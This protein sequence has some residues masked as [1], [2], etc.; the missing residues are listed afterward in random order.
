[1]PVVLAG[2]LARRGISRAMITDWLNPTLRGLLPDPSLLTDMDKAVNRLA[3]AVER[4]EAVGIFGDY[5]VD[6]ASSAALVHDVLTSL[7]MQVSIHIPDRFNEGYG[8]N[9]PAL[10]ALR[11]AGCQL[12]LTVDCGITAHDPLAAAS[13]AGVE[14][15]VIDHHVAGPQLPQAT[16]VVNPN[17]LEDGGEHG[18]LAAAGVCFLVMVGLLRCLRQRGFFADRT[19]PS[20]MQ[21]LDLVAL[22]TIADVVPLV[23]LNR[24]FVRRG[25]EVMARRGR[26]GLAALADQAQVDRP[27][28]AHMLGF[29]LGPRINA[30]GRIGQSSLGV[31]T[32]INTDQAEALQ[33]ASQLEMLNTQRRDHEQAV[34][35]AAIAELEKAPLAPI[36]MAIGE[37]WHQ[38]VIGIA[39]SR[40][41]DRYQRPACVIAVEIDDDGRRI[42]KASGRSVSGFRLG[43]A[44]IAACQAGLLIAGGGHDM[45]AG[46]TLDMAKLELFRD[47]M[48]S[49]L[50]TDMAALPEGEAS[51]HQIDAEL[52]VA[53]ADAL[54]LEWMA[55]AG[56]W[57]QS[58]PEPR[59][60]I[61]SARLEAVRWLGKGEAHI[62]FSISQGGMRLDGVAFRVGGMPV[63]KALMKAADGRPVHLTGRLAANPYRGARAVQ[64]L[65]DDL[66]FV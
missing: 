48:E 16:A 64:F 39:A 33:L 27:P 7:G 28:D 5:D 43:P 1:M 61:T 12:I 24:A 9:L 37:G 21:Q 36:L 50:A 54:L 6:G 65:L 17:R 18:Y 41:K 19:E 13:E 66:A 49:R 30:A 63:G 15:L 46:F 4:G 8:P 20:L 53:A 51:E 26:P 2:V 42:G 11:D 45:A 56:P 34:T 58:A 60:V 31:Q 52:P 57:G 23:G 62:G 22:A 32:L 10:L 25:L 29:V 14:V 3:D 35:T 38:G 55:R 59:F 44:V 47:F 40:L